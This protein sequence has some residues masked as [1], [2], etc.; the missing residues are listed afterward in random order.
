MVVPADGLRR[1]AVAR[2]APVGLQQDAIDVGEFDG[3]CLRAHGFEQRAGQDPQD[4]DPGMFIWPILLRFWPTA[5]VYDA[6]GLPK[7]IDL[8]RTGST[9]QQVAVQTRN[10]AGLVTKRRTDQLAATGTMPWIESNWT[11]DT[12][13]RVASQTVQKGTVGGG[14]TPTQ[15]AKQQLTYTGG[16]DPTT[17]VHTMGP[18]TAPVTRTLAFTYDERHQLTHAT[19][20]TGTAFDAQYAFGPAGR[21]TNVNIAQPAAVPNGNDVKPRNVNYVYGGPT[22]PVSP[23][24]EQVTAL[25]NVAD[26]T[27]Y[28]TFAYD[29]AGNQTQRVIGDVAWLYLYDGEDRLRRVTKKSATTPMLVYSIE[30][31]WYDE[32]GSRIGVLKRDGAG[33]AQELIWFIGDTQA[34]YTAAGVVSKV[35]SHLSLGTPVARVE[36]TGNTTTAIEY[37]FHG[38]ASNTIAAVAADGTVNANVVYAPYGEVLEAQEAG[39]SVF[40][41]AGHRRRFNDKYVDEIGGLGYYGARYY[42]NVLIGWTQGDPLYRVAPDAAWSEP[43]R[44][45]LYSFSG[46]N[47]MRYIDPDGRDFLGISEAQVKQWSARALVDHFLT[48]NGSLG[49]QR[50]G[51]EGGPA[52]M[53]QAQ[54]DAEFEAALMPVLEKSWITQKMFA[55]VMIGQPNAFGK[56]HLTKQA[57]M[58]DGPHVFWNPDGTKDAKGQPT[59]AITKDK[60]GNYHV[61]VLTGFSGLFH[62]LWHLSEWRAGRGNQEE[63]ATSQENKVREEQGENERACYDCVRY[64]V[65]KII[66]STIFHPNGA[67][68][69]GSSPTPQGDIWPM[70]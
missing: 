57:S 17:L 23:D 62:E 49:L 3:A 10:F 19:T 39:G 64:F 30:E 11:Y 48:N 40:G 12:W 20:T 27:P 66:S 33:V 36:R 16:D 47:P 43:R 24:P 55:K 58:Q 53:S 34:H 46:Q 15:I 1:V 61:E 52:N 29:A 44:A 21:F 38:M 63:E 50:G 32:N 69:G 18:T 25:T 4:P 59:K 8:S 7:R 22:N 37:Q 56:L 68:M 70:P 45:M 13:A 51:I 41:L 5:P 60:S 14:A 67:G 42:D 65:K 9:I 54:I 31:Y 28:A 2:F 35:L 6:R 26:S